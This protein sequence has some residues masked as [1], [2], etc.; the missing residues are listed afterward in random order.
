MCKA[1][2]RSKLECLQAEV[3]CSRWLSTREGKGSWRQCQIWLWCWPECWRLLMKWEC[4]CWWPQS[5]DLRARWC[6]FACWVEAL[7]LCM[8]SFE[9]GC[10]WW[11]QWSQL[12]W[13]R[14]TWTVSCLMK[15]QGFWVRRHPKTRIH[16]L[17]VPE[18]W[19]GF[20]WWECFGHSWYRWVKWHFWGI[21]TRSSLWQCW[22]VHC[23]REC[24]WNP[25]WW[26][27]GG[28]FWG[29]WRRF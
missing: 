18:W 12:S 5:S 20:H 3:W 14:W 28:R 2:S 6:S 8:T 4:N 9:R 1:Y 22:R 7:R 13:G 17:W 27:M 29:S 11:G 21:R 23:C 15:C 26:L 10:Q 25:G 24:H 16:R 19:G